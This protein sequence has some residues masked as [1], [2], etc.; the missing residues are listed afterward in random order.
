MPRTVAL[1]RPARRGRRPAA[2]ARCDSVAA[3]DRACTVTPGRNPSRPP[4]PRTGAATSTTTVPP[5]RLSRM[6]APPGATRRPTAVRGR[7]PAGGGAGGLPGSVDHPDLGRGERDHPHQGEHEGDQD[8]QHDRGFG[9]HRAA[10]G[11]PGRDPA[12]AP[13]G[14]VTRERA[15]PHHLPGW[16]VERARSAEPDQLQEEA[17]DGLQQALPPVAHQQPEQDGAEPAARGGDHGVLRRGRADLVAQP[18][19]W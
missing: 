16:R 19:L 5:C 11:A 15:A 4:G 8:G 7:V 9:G 10:L 14:E 17:E 12:T 2:G 13:V 6:L 1:P 3:T 18:G